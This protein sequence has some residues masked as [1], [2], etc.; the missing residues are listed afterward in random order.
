MPG[1]S[2][3]V[4]RHTRRP[5]KPPNEPFIITAR[6]LRHA[7]VVT[8]HQHCK[9]FLFHLII[10]SK[11]SV[12]LSRLMAMLTTRASENGDVLL[13]GAPNTYLQESSDQSQSLPYQEIRRASSMITQYLRENVAEFRRLTELREQVN[14]PSAETLS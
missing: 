12:G 14:E 7:T 6:A 2:L 1:S 11:L 10:R 9:H 8:T 4:N 3:E 13:K 5:F